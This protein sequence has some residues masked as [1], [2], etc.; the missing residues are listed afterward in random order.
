[1]QSTDPEC[2]VRVLVEGVHDGLV[3]GGLFGRIEFTSVAGRRDF[4]DDLSGGGQLRE[5][6]FGLGE[7]AGQVLYLAAEFIGTG[8]GSVM[9][10]LEI[11]QELGDVHT[12][13]RRV[14]RQVGVGVLRRRV[15]FAVEAQWTVRRRCRGSGRTR[16]PGAGAA[17]GCH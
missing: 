9:A 17:S 12:A 16:G 15:M 14:P 11:G 13:A 4:G 1:M 2:L 8:N 7:C 5:T 6:R 10:G 3:G